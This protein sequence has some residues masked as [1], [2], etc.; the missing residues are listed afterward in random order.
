[1]R[2]RDETGGK[3]GDPVGEILRIR[4]FEGDDD[5]LVERIVADHSVRVVDALQQDAQLKARIHAARIARPLLQLQ[6]RQ[7]VARRRVEHVLERQRFVVRRC[8]HLFARCVADQRQHRK[9]RQRDKL[10][11]RSVV[12]FFA[13]TTTTNDEIE[14]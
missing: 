12:L 8:Q 11:H 13:E 14:I 9:R 5:L 3:V 4:A 10:N 1:V 6:V 7:T 2:V